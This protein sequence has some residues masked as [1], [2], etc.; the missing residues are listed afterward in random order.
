VIRILKRKLWTCIAIGGTLILLLIGVL[1][2]MRFYA[3]MNTYETT[4]T[5]L[6]GRYSV[7]GGEWKDVRKDSS[8][9][10][11]FHTLEL[12]GTI[13]SKL[14][15]IYEEIN[16]STKDVWFEFKTAEG[17]TISSYTFEEEKFAYLHQ[18]GG[19]PYALLLPDTPG[20]KVTEISTPYLLDS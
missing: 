8:I 19:K 5:L 9:D 7:D 11:R 2:A 14:L 6:T 20:Y 3:G 18:K 17:E 1:F 16:I 12:R 10:E 15:N 4:N 13:S